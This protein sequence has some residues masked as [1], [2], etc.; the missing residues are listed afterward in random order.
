M[1]SR[2]ENYDEG[3]GPSDI[4]QRRDC[5]KVWIDIRGTNAGGHPLKQ[6]EGIGTGE[7]QTDGAA[8]SVTDQD[9]G[10]LS[11][12]PGGL[13]RSLL[14][15]C[16]SLRS[17]SDQA[18]HQ[19]SP[20]FGGDKPYPNRSHSFSYAR[21][22]RPGGRHPIFHFEVGHRASWSIV[23]VINFGGVLSRDLAGPLFLLGPKPHAGKIYT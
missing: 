6:R 5:D 20:W 22:H 2:V 10:S 23:C 18:R 16:I 21:G 7:L 17:S 11:T 12:C 3:L 8:L 19:G 9:E 14:L 4:Y 1:T 15:W 13:L